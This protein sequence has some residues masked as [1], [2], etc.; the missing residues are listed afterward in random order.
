MPALR[1]IPPMGR[2]KKM[3]DGKLCGRNEL[4][5]K[6]ILVWTGEERTRK[7]I[8][9]HI[10]V[11]KGFMSNDHE[12]IKHVVTE[13]TTSPR[14]GNPSI[15]DNIDTSQLRMEDE[16]MALYAGPQYGYIAQ[17]AYVD[18]L[19]PPPPHGILGSNAPHR[20]PFLHRIEFEMYV[21]SP[22][23]AK[24]HDYTSNQAEM[25][26]PPRALEE[27]HNWRLSY[28]LL[29]KY[30]DRGQLDSEMVLIQS[31]LRLYGE[32][33]PHGST[34]SI[35]FKVNAAGLS[36]KEEWSTR[37]EYYEDGQP[38]DMK[39]FYAQ[40][41][42]FKSFPWDRPNVSAGSGSSDV[43]LEIPLQSTWWVQLFTNMA[44]RKQ[45]TRR[46]PHSSQREEAYSRRYLHELSIMQELWASDG[47]SRTRVAI[48]LWK[49][50]QTCGETGTTTWR[51][52]NP[53]P[54]RMEVNSPVP[55]PPPPL[56]HSM[57]LDSTLHNL[58][59]PQAISVN[60]ERFLH[61]VNGFTE[62]TE[63]LVPES[64][65]ARGSASPA[66]SLDYTTSFPSS[67]STSFPPSVTHGYL[68]QEE[69]QDSAC[70]PQESECSR[71]G[72]L[73][74]QYSLTFPQKSIYAY[75]DPRT[76]TD[77]PRYFPENQE[78]ES[79]DVVYY[80]QQSFDSGS[81]Y[82]TPSHYGSF[83]GELIH[84]GSFA[85]H[86]Y[87]GGHHQL[88]L[89]QDGVVSHAQTTPASIFVQTKYS[90]HTQYRANEGEPRVAA[91]GPPVAELNTL[92]VPESHNADF[93]FSTLE[94]HFT[95][96]EIADIRNQGSEHHQHGEFAELLRNPTEVQYFNYHQDHTNGPEEQHPIRTPNHLDQNSLRH[97]DHGIVLGEAEEED[98]G[99]VAEELGFG[100]INY[101]EIQAVD[102]QV[103]SI[104]EHDYEYHDRHDAL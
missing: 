99:N 92:A 88:S 49:F 38:V 73:D 84:D 26:A 68:S 78:V 100:E 12:W 8:S 51:K 57:S 55:S 89:E 13:E 48:I 50:S 86:Q 24:I 36:G 66:P 56:Q 1:V 62:D 103:Q 90:T 33:P 69:S 65:S 44:K 77:D 9:S 31:N 76:Y 23:G 61:H 18:A 11:L 46:H 53:P 7:Q 10:Q 95:P 17:A 15:F 43:N 16:E 67:T 71:K 40:N 74:H 39:A 59:M 25:G 6:K 80:S 75:E 37:T 93:D 45:N 104:D 22:S 72:S 83:E 19:A 91:C 32:H 96:E 98:F 21:V 58:V 27:V 63:H 94:A 82:P 30:Y 102:G 70:Y 14:P 3:Q 81:H 35:G 85:A 2:K 60:T 47:A 5:M 28:P 20:G 87:T 64:Q 97:T 42:M 79:Q 41:D 52:L 4:L 29:E 101:D 54:I 34:L